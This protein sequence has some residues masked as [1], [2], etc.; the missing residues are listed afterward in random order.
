MRY[1]AETGPL[2]AYHAKVQLSMVNGSPLC[3]H[4]G[5][6]HFSRKD[7]AYDFRVVSISDPDSGQCNLVWIR[8][9]CRMADRLLS[10]AL[11]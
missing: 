8:V 1:M 5:L 4:F 11:G 10:R 9:R 3:N 7:V 6:Q 2:Y